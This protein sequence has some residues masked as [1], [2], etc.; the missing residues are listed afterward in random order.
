MVFSTRQTFFAVTALAIVVPT[1]VRIV[2]SPLTL[3]LLLPVL[4][5]V[6]ALGFLALNIFLGYLLDVHRLP[7][8]N[9]LPSAAR[10]LAFS[11]P[12]AWQAVLTRSQWSHK[13]PQ[14]LPPL[15]RD[16]PVISAALNDILIM[17]VRD[18]VLVWYKDISSSPSF[19][20]A[21]SS[22]LH[23]SMEQVLTRV[24]TLD[25]S[26]L[27]VKCIVPKVT[28]HIEQFRQSEVALRG[29]GLER[30]LTQSEELDLL[31]ASRYAGR[32][33]EKLHRAV[34]NLSSTFTKQTEEN[35]LRGLVDRAL[36]Y[37]LPEKE[38]RSEAV[39]IV[40]REIVACSV[41]YPIMEMLADPDFW[42]RSIDS[43]AGAAIRQ[44]RLV[45]KV[46][47]ILEA[48]LPRPN[49]SVTVPRPS[50]TET[51]TIRTDARQFESFLRSINRCSS[52]LDAR[53]L[54]NDIMGEIR[55]TRALLSNHEKDDWINGEKTE[56]IVAFLDR[57]YTAKRKVEKR[58]VLL[59]GESDPRQPTTAPE[60]GMQSHLTLRDVL[61]NP[62]SLS[63]F[64]EFMDR[65]HRSLLVQ[66]WLTVESFKNPLESVDS[67][68][69]DED[70][71]AVLDPTRS[72]T[73]KEDISMMNELYF[74]GTTPDPVL[75]SISQKHVNAIR[76]FGLG[77]ETPTPV[78][79]RRVR[80]SVMLTQR[81]IEREMEQ[82]FEDFQRSE[83]WFRV[84]GDLEA[85][86]RRGMDH[87]PSRSDD[88]AIS[89]TA[90]EAS[91]QSLLSMT[92]VPR[93]FSSPLFSTPTAQKPVR[94]ELPSSNAS[95]PNTTFKGSLSNLEVLMSPIAESP[96]VSSSRAP[97]FDDPEDAKMTEQSRRMAAI[98]AA[99]T[100]IIA[101]DKRDEH[102]V[103][104]AESISSAKLSS[105]LISEG[106]RNSTLDYDVEEEE[107][108]PD[109]DGEHGHGS[110]QLAGPG[111]LQLSHEIARLT[112]KIE[113]LQSQDAMLDTLIKKAELT[114]DAQ[115][116]RLLRKSRS[117]LTREL[118]ELRFQKTQYEQQ[119][120]A[121]RLL[122]DHTKVAIVNST[123]GEEDGK[124][125]VRYLIE[126]QQL[127]QDGTFS[128]GWV[129][130][131]RYNEFFNMH[132]K[133]RER[134]A[135][136][137]NLDFPGKRLVTALS[138]SF[139]D[140]RRVALEKYLQNLIA[141]PAVCESEELRGFLSRESPFI[142]NESIASTSKTA[143]PA[144]GKG[145]VR[146]MYQ[147]VTE[148]IDDMFFGPSMLDVIIQR[149]TTQA[150]E[151]AGIV[152]SGVHDEDL[153]AQ[154]LKASGKST[155]DD[156]LFQ[157]SGDLRPLQGETSTSTFSSPI[158]DLV[159]A[160]FELDKKNNWLRRQAI[161]IILQQ[162]FGD[163]IERKIRETF[164]MYV[165]ELHLVNYINIFRDGL[166]PGGQLK[167]PSVPRTA[168]EKLR[169]RDEANRKLSAL[170][171]DLVANMIG[172]SNARRGARRIFAVLQNRRLN[173]H[174]LYTIVDEIFA[175]LFPD[176]PS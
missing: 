128:S 166:W 40:V 102:P 20:T 149:L 160:V 103:G 159:L 45:S 48:Q 155:P 110:F 17:I 57:L 72:A 68:S 77:E 126:V 168:E 26:A 4:A 156:A 27:I 32:G 122:S 61:R 99:L 172:R 55:R 164:A 142:A 18:F 127:A 117:S 62:S 129:V 105:S 124:S 89:R 101:L 51:I 154:A 49:P 132:N 111:D 131:R 135:L 12:A 7:P 37:I 157:L 170:M 59:G 82:D 134:Y 53:R 158:C 84:V 138:S 161:V 66:F 5:V 60:A 88:H 22:V 93:S 50:T 69:S 33:G 86:A 115:E 136:V 9:A 145:I 1:A 163:T 112:H 36:P 116:L 120:S 143:P 10:P 140:Q 79:E 83:L 8:H 150:A 63:Y 95:T 58:I 90:S 23:S 169:T 28:A 146:S 15:Y 3:I 67:G 24:M 43:V 6:S 80:R 141:N 104:S 29:A 113:T 11:T 130:A 108:R 71:D 171:P 54:K 74:S 118:R 125:V 151:F 119:E 96:S 175:A 121:N 109:D 47:N 174:L 106:K 152:G 19:P 162:V 98:Q 35:H 56:D 173:Q 14:S 31:L 78:E 64:M 165:D 42:N 52:L 97:L 25:I 139:V 153:V 38:A 176:S 76:T 167:P 34:D 100:D 30:R 81:Q 73:L 92:S 107:D 70:D 21:V 39:K 75:S 2:S 46:R 13:A 41:L 94:M 148:S 91:E 85:I 133:L 114:G 44:Q 16:S 147:S 87:P 65:R 137:R 144:R 123:V